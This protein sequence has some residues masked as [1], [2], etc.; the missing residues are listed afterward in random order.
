MFVDIEAI[1][2]KIDLEEEMFTTNYAESK[3]YQDELIR[4]AEGGRLL[5]S[6]KP[7]QE[8]NL[9][10]RQIIQRIFKAQKQTVRDLEYDT[11]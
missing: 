2:N 1:I 7:S 5:K 11:L 8:K 3:A 6:A 9:S 10:L 4:Q